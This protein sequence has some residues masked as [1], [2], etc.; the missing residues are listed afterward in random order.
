MI[1]FFEFLNT[2]SPLRATGYM[3]FILMFFFMGYS[4]IDGIVKRIINR[5]CEDEQEVEDSYQQLND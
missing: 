3:A 4:F 2:C 5:D 1:D